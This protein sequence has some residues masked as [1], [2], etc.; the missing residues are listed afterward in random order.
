[1]RGVPIP[2]VLSRSRLRTKLILS[3]GLVVAIAVVAFATTLISELGPHL[4]G[5]K[6]IPARGSVRPPDRQPAR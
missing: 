4:G 1:M 3:Y 2:R 5:T 6:S